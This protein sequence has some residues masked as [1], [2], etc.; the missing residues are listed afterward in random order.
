MG[1]ILV[2]F[3][4]NIQ[5]FTLNGFINAKHFHL[6]NRFRHLVCAKIGTKPHGIDHS[7]S[8]EACQ[9]RA[10]MCQEYNV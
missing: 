9:C 3:V 5:P 2:I 10:F 8:K 6:E 7:K 4:L 1:E